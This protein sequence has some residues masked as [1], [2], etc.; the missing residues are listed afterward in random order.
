MDERKIKNIPKAQ[1]DKMNYYELL[2]AFHVPVLL[3]EELLGS[4][5]HLSF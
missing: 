5:Y 4:D 2:L 3:T 1:V